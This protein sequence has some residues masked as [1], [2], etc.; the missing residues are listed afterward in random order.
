MVDQAE[1]LRSLRC[2]LVSAIPWK[3]CGVVGRMGRRS[4]TLDSLVYRYKDTQ[5]LRCTF[6]C[7]RNIPS[8]VEV[9]CIGAWDPTCSC[10]L[11]GRHAD[12]LSLV[13][14]EPLLVD[15]I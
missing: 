12:Q 11:G 15:M 7:V 3:D 9:S 14:L 1:H 13:H 8:L 4:E 2:C 5:G 6:P 10:S